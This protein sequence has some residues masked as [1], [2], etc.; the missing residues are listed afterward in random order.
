MWPNFF[1]LHFSIHSITYC[2]GAEGT[3]SATCVKDGGG[4]LIH[5][6][7]N[8]PT[9]VGIVSTGLGSNCLSKPGI[10]T[11]ISSKYPWIM[12]T[13]CYYAE[14]LCES[15]LEQV[16]YAAGMDRKGGNVSVGDFFHVVILFLYPIVHV[17]HIFQIFPPLL[18]QTNSH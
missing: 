10:S 12:K 17:S 16:C 8:V 13:A 1:L 9:Q 5:W 4:P 2:T 3:S 18:M 6:K 14:D 7:N 15:H 11:R